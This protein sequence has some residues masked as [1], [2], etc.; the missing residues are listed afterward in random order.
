LNPPQEARAKCELREEATAQ[1]AHDV[2][3]I[4][5]TSLQDV[6]ED[7]HGQIDFRRGRGMSRGK[8][9]QAFMKALKREAETTDN[10]TFTEPQA[11]PHFSLS[12]AL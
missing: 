12:H 10:Q 1:D 6:L 2:V 11:R 3:E 4:I 7:Q 8:L 9:C 5:K